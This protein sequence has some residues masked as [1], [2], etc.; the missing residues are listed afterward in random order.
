[1]TDNKMLQAIFDGQ[2][3]IKEELKKDIKRVETNLSKDIKQ[4]TKE[5]KKNDER[6]D[7][8]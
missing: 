2:R 1:M 6:I 7:G 4:N 8:V 3:A 5:I